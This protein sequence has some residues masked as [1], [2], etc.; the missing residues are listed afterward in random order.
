LMNSERSVPANPARPAGAGRAAGPAAR[1]VL[2]G[3]SDMAI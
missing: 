3:R 1:A 2:A